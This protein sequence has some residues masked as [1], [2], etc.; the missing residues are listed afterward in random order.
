MSRS[1]RQY[2]YR[3]ASTPFVQPRKMSLAACIIRCPCT[4]RS[5]GCL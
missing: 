2:K 3:F 4:T 5:P 1:W